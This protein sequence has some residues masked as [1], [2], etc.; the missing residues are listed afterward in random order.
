MKGVRIIS[1]FRQYRRRIIIIRAE[2]QLVKQ[3][4][5]I[6]HISRVILCHRAFFQE[7]M[8]LAPKTL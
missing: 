4:M 2:V 7:P 1:L 8:N 3:L 6:W 5:K